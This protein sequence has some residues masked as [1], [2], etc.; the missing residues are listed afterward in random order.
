MADLVCSNLATKEELQ[1]LRDQLNAVLGEKEGGGEEEIFKAGIGKAGALTTSAVAL[2]GLTKTRAAEAITGLSFQ[3]IASGDIAGSFASGQAKL[4]VIQGGKATNVVSFDQFSKLGGQ[5]AKATGLQGAG[6]LNGAAGVTV[7]ASLVTIAATLALN[8]I[9]VDILDKRMEAESRGA[10][11]QIDAVNSSMLRLYD[12][13]QGDID[14]VVQ[15]LDAN[16]AVT[17]ANKQIIEATEKEIAEAK[18]IN[19][20]LIQEIDN[21]NASITDLQSQN[22]EFRNQI[23]QSNLEAQEVVNNLTGQAN[24]IEAELGQAIELINQ[25]K[26]QI[27][28]QALRVTQLEFTIKDLKDR[29][30][31][32]ELQYVLLREDFLKL[33]GELSGE[34]DLTNDTVTSLEGKI[35]KVQ[36]FVQQNQGGS[37][38]PAV[39]AAAGAQTATLQLASQLTSSNPVTPEITSTDIQNN[40]STFKNTF[41]DLLKNINSGGQVNQQQL[42]K[43]R[44]DIGIDVDTIVKGAIPASLAP[45]LSAVKS[46]TTKLRLVGAAEEALCNSL[47][48]SGTCPITP[49]N[50]T[51]TQGLGGLRDVLREQQDALLAAMGAADLAQGQTI[52]GIVKSTNAVVTDAKHGLEAVQNFAAKAWETTGAD[53]ILN[54]ITT[55]MVVHNGV[56]LSTNLSATVTETASVVLDAMG[57]KDSTTG[58]AFDVTAILRTKLTALLTSLVGAENYTTLTTK[59]AQYNRIYQTGANVLDASRDLFDSARST[60]ELTAEN[61]GRIGNALIESGVVSEDSYSRMTDQVNPQSKVLSRIEGFR[62]SLDSIEDTVSTIDSI[63]SNVVNT[64]SS[65]KELLDSRD[66]WNTAN[67]NLRVLKETEAA[68]AKTEA[69][70]TADISQLDFDRDDSSSEA[71]QE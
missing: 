69:E 56:Q 39:N 8:K 14:K 29:I 49:G 3:G 52:L 51:P 71:S 37:S 25:H 7:L 20:Q 57:I 18:T 42:D 15:Q 19:D 1:E 55:A 11:L 4:R 44:T 60:A 36:K 47:N 30:R 41:Q 22:V 28:K 64:K 43:L 6:G 46:Q 9:T 68:L 62:D 34:I 61:T 27:L 31:T 48:G 16:N 54:A 40:T 45:D 33:K 17:E 21:A 67:E 58:E 63:A 66:E 10:Q 26:Q 65:Y 32:V 38:L 24:A 13:N 5:T 53:K 12:K 70:V 35:A 50:P 23:Q 2:W 59:L